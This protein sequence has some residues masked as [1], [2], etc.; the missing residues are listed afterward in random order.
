MKY[1]AAYLLA[2]AGGNATPSAAD[3]KAI[4]ESVGAAV[5]EQKLNHVIAKFEGKNI[6]ELIEEGA[7]KMISTGAAVAAAPAA[8]A[9]GA[10]AEEAPKEE[11][12]EEEPA[13]P[14]DLG[15]MFDF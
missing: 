14:L 13:A 2:I 8:G 7:K 1:V 9:A 11:A 4:L 6:E 5:D 15:D 12:K 3:V 10:A